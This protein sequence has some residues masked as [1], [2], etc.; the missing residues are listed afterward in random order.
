M[1]SL[2]KA[3]LIDIV[4]KQYLYKLKAN[5][6]AFSSLIGIQLLALLLSFTG[7]TSS[8][9]GGGDVSVEI[10][11][12]TAD[13]IIIFTLIW[14]LVTAITVTTKPNRKHEFSFVTNRL[15]SS[16]S[17]IMFLVTSCIIGGVTSIL[18]G[19]LLR[20]INYLFYE[21]DYYSLSGDSHI[22]NEMAVAFLYLV[23]MSSIGYIIGSLVQFNKIF[24]FLIP[25]FVVGTL[26]WGGYTQK[27]PFL[28]DV[29]QFYV[30]ETIPFLFVLKIVLTSGV[31]FTIAI[32]I[33]NRLEV[34]K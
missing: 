4:T 10:Q 14:S 16:L 11:Y 2:P 20:V 24:V 1:M 22:I 29:F 31:L 30:L 17:N 9:M 34:R 33:F 15:S 26:I 6:D 27:E 13:V 25:A 21:R 3:S 32:Q 28:T 8:S 23:L 19:N 12:F 5:I 7:S 18:A